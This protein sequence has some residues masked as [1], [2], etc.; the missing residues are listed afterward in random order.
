MQPPCPCINLIKK[1][2][3]FIG[4]YSWNMMHPQ[5]PWKIQIQVPKTT[6]GVG[7]CSLAHNISR[8]RG[9]CESSKMRTKMIDKRINYSYRSAIPQLIVSI[10][11]MVDSIF[12]SLWRQMQHIKFIQKYYYIGLFVVLVAIGWDKVCF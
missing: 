5:T 10:F 4:W 12:K 3:I 8:V 2:D 6:E 9:L 1:K 7:I 11:M